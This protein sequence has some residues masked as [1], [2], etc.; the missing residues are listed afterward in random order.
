MPRTGGEGGSEREIDGSLCGG[1]RQ[2]LLVS[3][4][5]C[6]NNNSTVLCVLEWKWGCVMAHKSDE[7]TSPSL[8]HTAAAC[9]KE[10]SVEII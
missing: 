10:H 1:G 7:M 5:H 3:W 8:Q 4:E 6:N 9:S 2:R